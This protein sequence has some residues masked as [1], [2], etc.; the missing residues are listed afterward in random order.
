M[1]GVGGEGAAAGAGLSDGATST[2]A[3]SGICAGARSSGLSTAAGSGLSAGA[4][5]GLAARTGAF[6]G[7]ARVTA[8]RFDLGSATARAVGGIAAVLLPAGGTG[9][10]GGIDADP[11][12]RRGSIDACCEGFAADAV[13]DS[14]AATG[15]GTSTTL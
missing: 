7:A 15:A 1:T 5:G 12:A 6:T 2:A 13:A 4:T 9:D 10:V 14:P 3:G 8:F 11:V